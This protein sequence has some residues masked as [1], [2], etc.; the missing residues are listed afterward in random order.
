MSKFLNREALAA[1]L[2]ISPARVQQLTG[3]GVL[4]RRKGG[5]DVTESALSLAKYLRRDKAQ[6]AARVRLITAAAAISERRQRQVLRQ[7]V[8]LDEVRATLDIFGDLKGA[9][10]AGSSIM[11]AE[12]AQEVGEMKA[13]S[14]TGAVYAEVLGTLL[15]HRTAVARACKQLAEGL[16]E[17]ARLDEVAAQL[18]AAVGS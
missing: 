9:L 11:F 12:L 2:E 8:T 17:G 16:H 7:L 18:R 5:Y 13:R 10:Q 15:S 6:K 14:L 3:L 1:Q 4:T